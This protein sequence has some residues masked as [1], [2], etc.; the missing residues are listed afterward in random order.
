MRKLSEITGEDAMDVLAD[1]IEPLSEFT[2][3]ETFVSLIRRGKHIPAIQYAL[4]T[5]KKALIRALAIIEGENPDEYKPS[6]LKLPAMLLEVFNDP[7]LIAL[8]PSVEPVT[9]S[10]SVTEITE[11]EETQDLS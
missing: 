3:D 11:G 1:L 7:E 2:A 9:S 8:F 10:G 4:K 5:H 6:I